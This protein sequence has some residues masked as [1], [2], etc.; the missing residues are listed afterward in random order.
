MADDRQTFTHD[1]VSAKYFTEVPVSVEPELSPPRRIQPRRSRLEQTFSWINKLVLVILLVAAG[2][3]YWFNRVTIAS[4]AG[5]LRQRTSSPIDFALW[6]CGSK[7][8]FQEGIL[9]ATQKPIPGLEN[10]KPAYPLTNFDHVDFGTLYN[11]AG[12]HESASSSRWSVP[13]TSNHAE[14]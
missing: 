14:H 5:R 9:E 10:M 11:P 7:H 3:W 13:A 2:G 4:K 12:L 8:T 1:L 6:L